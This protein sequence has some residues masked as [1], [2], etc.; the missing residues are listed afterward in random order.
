MPTARKV[1]EACP[2]CDDDSDVW[3]FE[4][5]EGS[6]TKECYTCETCRYEW[7]EIIDR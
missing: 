2:R 5:P 3:L 1:E 7:S 6:V 4:K